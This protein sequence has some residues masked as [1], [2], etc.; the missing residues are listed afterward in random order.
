MPLGAVLG[1][2]AG[3]IGAGTAAAQT[4]LSIKRAVAQKKAGLGSGGLAPVNTPSTPKSLKSL[5]A[6]AKADVKA[7]G[8]GALTKEEIQQVIKNAKRRPAILSPGESG[9]LLDKKNQVIEALTNDDKTK[10]L[11]LDAIDTFLPDDQEDDDPFI[12][13]NLPQ[14]PRPFEEQKQ[15]NTLMLILLGIAGIV[16]LKVFKV[17]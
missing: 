3:L 13:I 7:V 1:K 11:L 6:D 14:L 10:N 5:L 4:G 12:D 16:A 2:I 8:L 9:I 17:F 15:N